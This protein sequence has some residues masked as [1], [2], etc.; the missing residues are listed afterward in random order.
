[1]PHKDVTRMGTWDVWPCTARMSPGWGRGTCGRAPFCG[2]S[3]DVAPY[4][5]GP[6]AATAGAGR[7]GA[8]PRWPSLPT[9]PWAS[10]L[11]SPRRHLAVITMEPDGWMPRGEG[12]IRGLK[13]ASPGI[14]TGSRLGPCGASQ[15]SPPPALHPV[16]PQPWGLDAAP[17]ACQAGSV[18]VQSPQ[19]S[20][21]WGISGRGA[22]GQGRLGCPSSHPVPNRGE[23]QRSEICTGVKN[24]LTD[25][26]KVPQAAPG[27]VSVPCPTCA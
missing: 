11:I 18:G 10:H 6:G 22:T 1:M 20:P 2:R 14:P 4:P 3:C 27:T 19:P 26:G 23:N 7:P 9:G 16:E 15:G 25:E 17:R 8:P 24:T 21:A 13:P 12:R 5:A